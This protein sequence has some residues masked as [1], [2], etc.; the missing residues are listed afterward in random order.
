MKLRLQDELIIPIDI[1][2]EKKNDE[3]KWKKTNMEKKTKKQIME[4]KKEED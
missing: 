1:Y 2:T 4:P 3:P